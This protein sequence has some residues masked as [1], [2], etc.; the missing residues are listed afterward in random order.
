M[1]L[2]QW[3]ENGLEQSVIP[4]PAAPVSSGNVLEVQILGS[5]PRPTKSETLE[6]RA[7]SLCFNKL[8]LGYAQECLRAIG[9]ES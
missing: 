4:G 6:V 2:G 7:N 8:F 5:H 9:L 3:R 1:Q